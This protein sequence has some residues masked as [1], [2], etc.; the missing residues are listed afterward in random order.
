MMKHILTQLDEVKILLS[1]LP[2]RHL[3]TQFTARPA[4][5]TINMR[6]ER[7]L[8]FEFIST[9]M[10]RFLQLWNAELTISYS[11][12]DTSLS[13]L[14]HDEQY[15]VTMFWLDWRLYRD[16]MTAEQAATW[17][18][19]RLQAFRKKSNQPLIVNNWFEIWELGDQLFSPQVSQQ[20]WV[21]ELNVHLTSVAAQIAGCHLIDLASLHHELQDELYD[22]RNDEISHFPLSARASIAMARLIAVQ[23]LPAIMRARLKVIVVDLD[24]TLYSGVLGEDGATGIRLS[25]GHLQLQRLLLKLKQSGILLAICSRNEH[26]DV[27]QLFHLRKEQ[28]PLKWQDFAAIKANWQPKSI[29]IQAISK[30][31]NIDPAEF[32]FIDDNM[33]ELVK[34]AATFPAIKLLHAEQDGAQTAA[35]LS[36]Y[37]GLYL[38]QHDETAAL[39]TTDLQANEQREQLKAEAVDYAT[40]LAALQMVVRIYTNHQPHAKRVHELSQKTN[41]FN[42]TLQRLSASEVE[43]IL[44]NPNGEFFTFTVQLTDSLSDSGIVGAFIFKVD[45][46]IVELMELVFSCRALGREVETVAFTRCLQVLHEQGYKTIRLTATTGPRNQPARQWLE[47]FVG[48]SDEL[49]VDGAQTDIPLAKLY[50]QVNDACRNHPAEIQLMP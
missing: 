2:S 1:S 7:T 35:V 15:D 49:K 26:D 10:K 43:R 48:R 34:V 28:M 13:Q 4:Q 12:Y 40:Y 6:I 45:N 18:K 29:N 47:R 27:A 3:L 22:E 11:D 5:T 14:D 30:Q 36:R 20:Q 32:L 38:L 25:E 42:L 24:D 50:A 31:L 21:R 9:M 16:S 44:M 8:P 39:R 17:L 37:P 46:S 23:L 33:A 41:Q 19:S